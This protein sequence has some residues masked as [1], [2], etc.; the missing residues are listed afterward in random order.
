MCRS[1]RT[2]ATALLVCGNAAA[3][4][5]VQPDAAQLTEKAIKA[6]LAG[7]LPLRRELLERAIAAAPDYAA[8]RWEAGQIRAGEQWLPV[9]Q[10]QATALADDTLARYQKLRET[11]PDTP[12]GH[13]QMARWCRRNRLADEQRYHWLRVLQADPQNEEALKSLGMVWYDGELV[14]RETA[15]RLRDQERRQAQAQKHWRSRIAAWERA[16]DAGD[17]RRGLTELR[18]EVDE[19]AILTFEK[20]AASIARASTDDAENRRRLCGA[21]L[22]ALADMPTFAAAES[23]VRFAL[24]APD[25]SHREYATKYL[26]ARPLHETVPLLL[27]GLRAPIESQFD[28]YVSPYG[29][30]RYSHE[31]VTNTPEAKQVIERTRSG[32]AEV[33]STNQKQ[34]ALTQILQV[35]NREKQNATRYAARLANDAVNLEQQIAAANARNAAANQHITSVLTDVT[36]QDYGSDPV[37]WWDFWRDYNEFEDHEY[38]PEFVDH[39]YINDTSYT[40]VTPPAYFRFE[41]RRPYGRSGR[42]CFVAGTPVWTKTGTVPIEHLSVGDLVLSR[43]MES[44]ELAF[45][46]VVATTT[47]KPSPMLQIDVNGRELRTTLGHP[48]WVAGRGWRMAKELAPGDLLHTVDGLIEVA[49]I[50]PTRDEQAFNLVVEG[51]SDYF[52]G[53]AGVLVHDNTPRRP[54][55]VQLGVR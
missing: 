22:E 7:D 41:D 12:Q 51:A 9:R 21:F 48:F 53:E 37:A 35:K 50:S 25:E 24:L 47:R 54:E 43:H 28:I 15:D 3:A 40:F 42:S 44:G 2:I 6:G 52:V 20:L 11:T 16:L 36:G 29:N 30:V 55:M 4:E 8:A 5:K 32:R 49:E 13:Y 26:A 27:R 31:L 19:S 34:P 17:A 45:R 10:A 23:L 14:P 38:P 39:R 1:I 46:P 33:V 18:E